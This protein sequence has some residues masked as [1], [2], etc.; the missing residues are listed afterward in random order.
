MTWAGAVPGSLGEAVISLAEAGGRRMAPI[1]IAVLSVL[2]PALVLA[3]CVQGGEGRWT[4]TTDTLPNGAAYVV[5]VPP[6]GQPE[7]TLVA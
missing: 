4:T 2:P 3:G 5:N 1:R 7:P 6:A